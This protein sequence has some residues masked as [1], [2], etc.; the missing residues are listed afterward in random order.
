MIFSKRLF[1][2]FFL[3]T[4]GTSLSLSA[5]AYEDEDDLPPVTL[6]QAGNLHADGQQARQRHVPILL[7]FAQRGCSWCHYVEEEQLK[8]MLRNADYRAQVIIR[9]VMTDDPSSIT[10]FDG[11]QTN[12]DALA[13]RYNASLTPTVVFVDDSG[14]LLAPRILGV[15]NTEYYG[16]DLD[17]GLAISTQKIR[18]QLAA[19]NTKY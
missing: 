4:L 14:K 17:D 3:L 12:A 18:Q 9:Q 8:P 19:L 5:Y 16:A 10:D 6:V 11:K 7:M 13:S 15:Q 2:L 1:A